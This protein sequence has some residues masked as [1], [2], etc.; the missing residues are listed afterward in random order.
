M[1]TAPSVL[2]ATCQKNALRQKEPKKKKK[3]CRYLVY[4]FY[5]HLN[6]GC[7]PN[8]GK[9]KKDRAGCDYSSGAT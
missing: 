7:N 4:R 1:L 6:A 5:Q 9:P 8:K 2:T 3:N